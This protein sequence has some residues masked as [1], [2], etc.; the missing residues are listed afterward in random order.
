[1]DLRGE[2]RGENVVVPRACGDARTRLH[3]PPRTADRRIRWGG[4]DALGS[5]PDAW[6]AGARP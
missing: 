2:L 6:S 1:M 4:T 5:V 3:G